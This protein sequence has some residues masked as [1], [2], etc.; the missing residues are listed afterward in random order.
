MIYM[1]RAGA[2]ELSNP[3]SDHHCWW[4]TNCYVNMRFGTA[5]LMKDDALSL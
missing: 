5:N 1:V 3:I 4:D 2:F